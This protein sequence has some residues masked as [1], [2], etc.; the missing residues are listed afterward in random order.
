MIW[1]AFLIIAFMAIGLGRRAS[2]GRRHLLVFIVTAVTL[3]I[4]Y[5]TFG[6]G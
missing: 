2:G 4:V 5:L 1:I 6:T 3:G